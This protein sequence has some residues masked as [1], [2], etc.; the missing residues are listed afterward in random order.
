ME[1]PGPRPGHRQGRHRSTPGCRGRRN[2]SECR[3]RQQRPA[4]AKAGLGV[5]A[6][7][8]HEIGL[9]ED[10]G[11]LSDIAL[12][13]LHGRHPAGRSRQPGTGF[14][15]TSDF[16]VEADRAVLAAMSARLEELGA[17][18]VER[19]GGPGDAGHS[20]WADPEGN[21]FC[22][23]GPSSRASPS[24]PEADDFGDRKA[25]PSV[26]DLRR[27]GLSSRAR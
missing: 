13:V 26:K 23:P 3:P 20:V 27:A 22:A 9:S 15:W 10:P 12:R 25:C 11:R 14:I 7:V 19:I 5:I 4:Q 21:V 1:A 17:R 18:R 8:V 2:A 24:S 16:A 6:R